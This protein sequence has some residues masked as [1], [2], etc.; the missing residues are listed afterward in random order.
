MGIRIFAKE[1]S[2]FVLCTDIQDLEDCLL[3]SNE[4]S[5]TCSLLLYNS[6]G[7]CCVQQMIIK[8]CCKPP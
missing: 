4:T 2:I 1:I 7:L 6:L 8:W 3:G 5:V